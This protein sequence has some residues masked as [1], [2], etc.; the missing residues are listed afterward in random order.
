MLSLRYSNVNAI[1]RSVK[2]RNLNRL[3]R[4]I[5]KHYMKQFTRHQS[6]LSTILILHYVNVLLYTIS[7]VTGH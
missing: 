2:L 4:V 5:N 7:Y 1:T 6:A 3:S